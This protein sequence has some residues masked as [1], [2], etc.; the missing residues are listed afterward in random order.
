LC[1]KK[2]YDQIWLKRGNI[3]KS[4]GRF[5]NNK[6]SY[7]PF[8]TSPRALE[9]D[10]LTLDT[11]PKHDV[12]YFIDYVYSKYMALVTTWL[13]SESDSWLLPLVIF[14]VVIIHVICDV[15]SITI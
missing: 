11:M 15:I 9:F 12:Y 14:L 13:C 5:D 3:G 1:V 8:E 10:Q 2:T 7:L 4:Y 6:S